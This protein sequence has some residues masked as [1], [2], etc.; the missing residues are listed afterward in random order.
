MDD[1]NIYDLSHMAPKDGN[2]RILLLGNFDPEGVREIRDP[3]CV[4]VPIPSDCVH[5]E[6]II[7]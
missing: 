4:S 2:A 5:H 1:D 7:F 3:Y 6:I